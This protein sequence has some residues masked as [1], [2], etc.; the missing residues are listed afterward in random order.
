MGL[1]T[2]IKNVTKV[3]LKCKEDRQFNLDPDDLSKVTSAGTEVTL[4]SK[5]SAEDDKLKKGKRLKAIQDAESKLQNQLSHI[6]DLLHHNNFE[7][8]IYYEG[9]V[10]AGTESIIYGLAAKHDGFVEFGP[11]HTKKD[12][13]D[14]V[15][16]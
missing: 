1:N 15:H 11:S 10:N 8:M 3:E 14:A 7:Y 4:T 5:L 9:D 16:V 2:D 13:T 6:R 12:I